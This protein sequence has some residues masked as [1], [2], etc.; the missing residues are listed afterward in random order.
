MI[1]PVY[2]GNKEKR[3]IEYVNN[4]NNF[5]EWVKAKIREEIG[6]DNSYHSKSIGIDANKDI[7]D[8]IRKV[9]GEMNINA[10]SGKDILT[11]KEEIKIDS[12]EA[13][14]GDG[15]DINMWSL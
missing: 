4:L 12:G 2:F 10:D 9:I 3:E 13:D 1:K 7:E 15:I 5:S 11:S 8:M 6:I 14:L